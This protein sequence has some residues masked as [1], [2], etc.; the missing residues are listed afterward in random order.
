M[1]DRCCLGYAAAAMA[2]GALN[3]LGYLREATAGGIASDHENI[4]QTNNMRPTTGGA[5]PLPSADRSVLRTLECNLPTQALCAPSPMRPDRIRRSSLLH[6]VEIGK[7]VVTMAI[8]ALKLLAFCRKAPAGAVPATL[9]NVNQTNHMRPGRR[10]RFYLAVNF[11][12]TIAA[13][14]IM[15]AVVFSER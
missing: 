2:L 15:L 14:M 1:S 4:N 9:K 10:R 8:G 6:M 7:K 3:L 12:M 11:P 5:F 13:T